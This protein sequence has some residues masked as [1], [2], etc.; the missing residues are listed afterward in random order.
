MLHLPRVE[1]ETTHRFAPGVYLRELAMPAGSMF[2]GHE[3]RTEHLCIVL[4]GRAR[5]LV[6]GE[7]PRVIRAGDVFNAPAGS[8]KLVVVDEAMRFLCVHPNPDDCHDLAE[9]EA[10]FIR[11]SETFQAA[12]I[13]RRLGIM[14]GGA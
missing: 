9:L 12:E 11:K 3:H 10:R 4:T 13:V 7:A 5:V 2:L 8:R 14:E 6:S 1:G